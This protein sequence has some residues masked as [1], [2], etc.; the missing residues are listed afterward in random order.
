MSQAGSSVV[1][2][3]RPGQSG[4]ARGTARTASK[5]PQASRRKPGGMWESVRGKWL[6][7]AI[8]AG[9]SIAVRLVSRK[10]DELR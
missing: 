6:Y 9:M 4:D 1:R 10:K 7:P 8:L 5:R 2:L 3:P